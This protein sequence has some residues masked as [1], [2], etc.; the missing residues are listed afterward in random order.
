[1]E[2]FIKKHTKKI[3]GV[4][5][6]FDRIIIKGYLPMR[7]PDA[8]G[9]FLGARGIRLKEFRP[10]A[11]I[12]T[13]QL[14]AY[15]TALCERYNRPLHFLHKPTEK[16]KLARSIAE[17]DNIARG[18]VCVLSVVESNSSFELRTK[19]NTARLVPCRP[20]CSTLYF[21]FID[22][23]FGFMHIRLCTWMPF[24][25]QVYLNGHE[26]LANKL[27]SAHID[28]NKWDNA[29]VSINDTDCAQTIA[30][31]FVKLRWEK[32]LHT[33]AR[34]VNPLFRTLLKG[35]EYYWVIDQAEFATDIMFRSPGA[36][37]ELFIKLQTHS[38]VCVK[39]RDI[40]IF[41]GRQR[42]GA[43][44]G[45]QESY[46]HKRHPGTR[47]KHRVN[48]NWIKM[49]DKHGIVLR[50]ETVINNPYEF[51][52]RRRRRKQGQVVMDWFPMIKRVTAMY[53]FAEVALCANKRYLDMLA[54]VDDPSAAYHALDKLCEQARLGKQRKRALNP[55]RNQDRKLFEA[56]MKG[57]HTIQGFRH[58][59]VAAHLGIRFSKDPIIKRRQSARVS[60]RI[61]LLRAHNLIAK[62]PK[63]RRYRLTHNGLQLMIAVINIREKDFPNM[64]KKAA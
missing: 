19:G 8:I 25:I 64:F 15:A 7:T 31:R 3:T 27:D 12:T 37:A 2:Q 23:V 20:R 4:I 63:S 46:Y 13:E 53:R 59:D 16:N 22:P 52:M 33:F 60:R 44:K 36:L 1:M 24:S 28:F 47:I 5:S 51:S 57:E 50:I 11:K 21:Y 18:L 9:A 38:V 32:I 58:A 48:G 62:I 14:K 61:Q 49:Y 35:M 42:P 54:A 29:F 6:T 10:F 41:L 30:D 17:K 56:V 43:F 45:N 26:W 40:M 39:P 55:L 34:R